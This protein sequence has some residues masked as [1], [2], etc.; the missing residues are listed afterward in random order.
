MA[1]GGGKGGGFRGLEVV[2]QTIKAARIFAARPKRQGEEFRRQFI[3]LF[4]RLGRVLG[5]GA[6]RHVADEGSLQGGG[7]GGQATAGLLHQ[8]TDAGAG[9][10]VRQRRAF[11]G[12]HGGLGEAHD[13]DLLGK[14]GRK[15]G[16]RCW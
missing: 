8:P 1:S 14:A 15:T 4:V 7:R 2:A 12:V 13:G 10:G 3:V 5:D 16:T 11:Q 6:P 9:H